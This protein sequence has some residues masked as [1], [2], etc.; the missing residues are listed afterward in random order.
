MS[1]FLRKPLSSE[2]K[3]PCRVEDPAL[4]GGPGFGFPWKGVVYELSFYWSIGVLQKQWTKDFRY[5]YF[6]LT[7]NLRSPN[8]VS[9]P[10]KDGIFDN[11]PKLHHSSTPYEEH[12]TAQPTDSDFRGTGSATGLSKI[13]SLAGKTRFFCL[14][15]FAM[16]LRLMKS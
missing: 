2:V 8:T 4:R 3:N 13:P 15:K 6:F 10:V 9:S 7:S 5:H 1:T 14:N 12:I 16:I 11:T